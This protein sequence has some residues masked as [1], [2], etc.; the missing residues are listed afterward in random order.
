MLDAVIG[1]V[2]PGLGDIGIEVCHS[3]IMIAHRRRQG[4]MNVTQGKGPRRER[5]VVLVIQ[6]AFGIVILGAEAE[7]EDGGH[8]AGLGHDHFVC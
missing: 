6:P 5:P 7:G 8:R 2:D 1:L 4:K 3:K